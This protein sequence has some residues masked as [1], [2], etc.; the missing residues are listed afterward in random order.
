MA[1]QVKNA[2][3]TK[4]R[5]VDLIVNAANGIGVMGAGVAGAIRRAAGDEFAKQVRTIAMASGSP[6]SEGQVYLTPPGNL[7]KHKVKGV[8]HAV[9]MKYPGSGCS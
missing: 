4:V 1:V 5:N 8:L 2:D 3:I 7:S 6:H 9:T